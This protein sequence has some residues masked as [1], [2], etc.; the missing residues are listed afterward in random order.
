MSDAEPYKTI[1]I[2]GATS[3]IGRA[4]ALAY[5]EPGRNLVLMGRDTAR[6]AAVKADCTAKGARAT[7][8]AI[9][10]RDRVAMAETIAGL[11]RET[12]IDLA[13]ANAGI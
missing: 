5:A 2:T 1:L 7:P 11:D 3:G 6:L 9:D 8:V 10:V 4:L 12:P 13:V